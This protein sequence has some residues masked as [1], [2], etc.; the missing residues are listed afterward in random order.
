ME[1]ESLSYANTTRC[2]LCWPLIRSP[3]SVS[4][5]QVSGF[6][7]IDVLHAFK[8]H[9]IHFKSYTIKYYKIGNGYLSFRC[10][11]TS[12]FY[13]YCTCTFLYFSFCFVSLTTP[14]VIFNHIIYTNISIVQ[15][16]VCMCVQHAW[17][18]K[19]IC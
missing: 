17:V 8:S 4:D 7:I 13:L 2:S 3:H 10:W 12:L 19:L 15:Q 1:I 14:E 6:I 9:A 5:V 18:R 16:V 11:L